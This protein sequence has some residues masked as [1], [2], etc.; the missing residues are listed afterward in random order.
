MSRLAGRGEICDLWRNSLVL[1]HATDENGLVINAVELIGNLPVDVDLYS[2]RRK[3]WH[4]DTDGCWSGDEL[5]VGLLNI[6]RPTGVVISLTAG[7][8]LNGAVRRLRKSGAN[9]GI[10][11]L[12]AA[13]CGLIVNAARIVIRRST[14]VQGEKAGRQDRKVSMENK[15]IPEMRLMEI[16]IDVAMNEYIVTGREIAGTFEMALVSAKLALV[17]AEYWSRSSWSRSSKCGRL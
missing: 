15:V 2:A 7:V 13:L 10:N 9:G 6:E 16:H 17:S 3:F 4:N 5:S 12:E 14:D 11:L 8:N 1:G